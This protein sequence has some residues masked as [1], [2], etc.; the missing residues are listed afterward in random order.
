MASLIHIAEV[1]AILAVAYLLGWAIGYVAH[2]VLART[3][4]PAIPAERVDAVIA[5]A[6]GDALVKAP[7]IVPVADPAT[8]P[9]AE[10]VVANAVEATEP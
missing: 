1:A 10:P 3:P 6:S 7:V 4:A 9:V 2:R 5:A 8:Q